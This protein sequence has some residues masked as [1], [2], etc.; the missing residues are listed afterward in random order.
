MTQLTILLKDRYVMIKSKVEQYLGSVGI[1]LVR[2]RNIQSMT[3]EEIGAEFAKARKEQV[4]GI[5]K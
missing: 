2:L 5:G 1:P 3:D 4:E